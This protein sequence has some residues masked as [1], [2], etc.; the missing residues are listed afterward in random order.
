MDVAAQPVGDGLGELEARLLQRLSALEA[1]LDDQFGAL[2]EMLGALASTPRREPPPQPMPVPGLNRA[3]RGVS[4]T[5]DMVGGGGNASFSGAGCGGGSVPEGLAPASAARGVSFYD[6]SSPKASP[7]LAAGASSSFSP[8]YS[9]SLVVVAAASGGDGQKQPSRGSPVG[10]PTPMT[11]TGAGR[12]ELGTKPLPL[13]GES[14]GDAE[15]PLGDTESALATGR[16]HDDR[17]QVGDRHHGAA[18]HGDRHDKGRHRDDSSSESGSSSDEDSRGSGGSSAS[19]SSFA[20]SAFHHDDED[21]DSEAGAGK[22]GVV[23]VRRRCTQWQLARVR[24]IVACPRRRTIDRTIAPL[25][26]AFQAGCAMRLFR[27]PS[28]L[29]LS[30]S[31]IGK[32]VG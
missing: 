7:P 11:L 31:C 23:V 6:E 27:L 15:E 9:P 30:L 24:R 20:E 32:R 25:R 19:F 22:T 4:L 5:P 3:P 8:S 18:G 2:R 21:E 14:V 17:T 28:R 1:R 29:W 10:T 13:W 12:E 16:H 26:G